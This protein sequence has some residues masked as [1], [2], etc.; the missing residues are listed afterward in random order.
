MNSTQ[1][2]LN[3]TTTT[4]LA[5][6]IDGRDYPL[7]TLHQFKSIE[8][9]M[10]F[11]R[12]YL[13]FVRLFAEIGQSKKVTDAVAKQLAASC[14]RLVPIVLAA[15]RPVLRALTDV[16]RIDIMTAFIKGS[17]AGPVASRT[18]TKGRRRRGSRSSRASRASTGARL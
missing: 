11:D 12:D 10:V 1:V 18:G 7:R 4:N 17:H 15:P 14:Q 3:L 2:V 13:P 6:R 9:R 16:Q 8:D 5:V